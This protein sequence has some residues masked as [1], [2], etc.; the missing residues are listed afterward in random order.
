MHAGMDVVELTRALIRFDTRN[1]PGHEADCARE[2]GTLLEGEGF[3]TE[4]HEFAPGRTSLVARTRG[5]R[6]GTGKALCFTG[7][8]D[9]VPLGEAEWQHDP[10]EAEVDDGRLYG[11]G[12]SDMKGGIAAMTLAAIAVARETDH[13]VPL[14]LV[15][16]A[17]EETGCEGARHLAGLDGVLSPTGAIVIGEPTGNYP[18][19]A[20]KGIFWLE[21]HTEG[22]TAH[23]S[24]PEEGDNALYKAARAITALEHFDFGEPE[25]PLLGA[26]SLNVS[27]MRGGLNMNS[28]PDRAM[29]GIDMRTLPGQDH[30]AL[31]NRIQDS[32]GEQVHFTTLQ[33]TAGIATPADNDWVREV[34][35]IM[36]EVLGA[37]PQERGASYYTDGSLLKPALDDPPTVIL[38]PGEIAQAHRTD[39]Y[40]EVEKLEAITGA[41]EEIARR[42]A[43][44][45]AGSV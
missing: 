34:F 35:D 45:N 37:M 9:V 29:F 14:E 36:A 15:F 7:H 44:R 43:R 31:R 2:L 20:H 22:V 33:D 41:Y 1:P 38:G 5:V 26:P 18:L 39:E 30:A 28:V 3:E 40:C 8:L 24:M 19:V 25:S 21:G 16:T 17:S 4:Y 12:T 42:W 6:E 11:R 10:F 32:V 23:G 27:V 13:Q